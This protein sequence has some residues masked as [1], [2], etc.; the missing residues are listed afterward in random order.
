M[1]QDFLLLHESSFTKPLK[2]SFHIFIKIRADIR[3]LRCISSINNIC[4]KYANCV[5]NTSSKYV[6]GFDYRWQICY[7]SPTPATNLLPE[8]MTPSGKL[9]PET[10]FA[11]HTVSSQQ[12]LK[13]AKV[14]GG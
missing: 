7:Q 14:K 10:K 6:A 13:K 2:R 1:S 5:N 11:F 3:K 9:P 4:C 12:T 8:S